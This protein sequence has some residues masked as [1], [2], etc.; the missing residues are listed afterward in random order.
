VETITLRNTTNNRDVSGTFAL[1]VQKVVGH[2]PSLIMF[3]LAVEILSPLILHYLFKDNESSIYA[4]HCPL[5][6]HRRIIISTWLTTNTARV[7]KEAPFIQ[8]RPLFC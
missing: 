3:V 5:P 2:P 6:L 7:T 8:R 4:A 1:S